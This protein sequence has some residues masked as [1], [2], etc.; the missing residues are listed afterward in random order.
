MLK[1]LR[2]TLK[3]FLG[4]FC[5][6]VSPVTAETWE[7]ILPL[8]RERFPEVPQLT[9]KALAEWLKK[10]E[11][12]LLVDARAAEEYAVSQLPGAIRFESVE[13]VKA[14]AEGRKI[15][16]YCSVGYRSSATA[17]K[18]REAGLGNVWNLEGS[19]FAWAN[20]GRPVYR[21]KEELTPAKVHPFDK[22]W[23]Q[24]LKAEYRAEKP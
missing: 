24:L 21:G 4:L 9:T 18:L 22:K 16:V 6:Y 3:A 1:P 15:V 23:G 5:L 8:I 10:E 19:I 13:Q 14:A 20:E 12:L 11:K 17:R 2:R 7:S